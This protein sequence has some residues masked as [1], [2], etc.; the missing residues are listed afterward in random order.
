MIPS[1]S[2]LG[3]SS[4]S[5]PSRLAI[6]NGGS[7]GAFIPFGVSAKFKSSIRTAKL[8]S[9]E[10]IPVLGLGTWA[11]GEGGHPRKQE[12]TAVRHALELGMTVID[13]AE[14][15]GDGATE[16]LVGEAIK[17]A[18]DRAF[19]VSKVLPEHATRRGTIAACDGSLRRLGTDRL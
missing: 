5:N 12:I 2:C 1:S 3:S 17:G 15:Y 19:L 9:G 4:F 16:R 13:T 8:P 14:M 18:R 11:M 6:W 10:A 7:S